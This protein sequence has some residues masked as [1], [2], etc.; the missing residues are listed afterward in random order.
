M[1]SISLKN[2]IPFGFSGRVMNTPFQLVALDEKIAFLVS[3]DKTVVVSPILNIC[4]KSVKHLK[5]MTKRHV[6]RVISDL[7]FINGYSI[8]FGVY[9]SI[10]MNLPDCVQPKDINFDSLVATLCVNFDRQDLIPDA[11]EFEVNFELLKILK[12]IN[13]KDTSANL[14]SNKVIYFDFIDS[15]IN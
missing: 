2:L 1:N 8:K 10:L 12:K 14:S 5:K 3:K 4:L 9:F 15:L 11:F 13:F 6:T 7:Y